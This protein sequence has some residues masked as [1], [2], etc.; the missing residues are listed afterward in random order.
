MPNLRVPK[1]LKCQYRIEDGGVVELRLSKLLR[2]FGR[3]MKVCFMTRTDNI[4]NVDAVETRPTIDSLESQA[5]ACGH[6]GLSA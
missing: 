1:E 6:F 5:T 4:V 2:Q 3:G